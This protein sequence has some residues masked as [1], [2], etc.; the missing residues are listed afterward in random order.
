MYFG[1]TSQVVRKVELV[2]I[3]EGF[4]TGHGKDEGFQP[5]GHHVKIG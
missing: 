4:V 2:E 3:L 5:L 1:I